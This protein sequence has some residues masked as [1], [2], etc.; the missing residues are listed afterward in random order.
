MLL[1][2]ICSVLS[3]WF[4]T[5]NLTDSDVWSEFHPSGPFLVQVTQ[6]CTSWQV[7]QNSPAL[8]STPPCISFWLIPASNA[9][10]SLEMGLVCITR[11]SFIHVDLS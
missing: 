10:H 9:F 2:V 7:Q 4:V 11:V 3:K 6:G 1:I 5:I 8:K